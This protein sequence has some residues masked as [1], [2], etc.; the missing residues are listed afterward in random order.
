MSQQSLVLSGNLGLD[1]DSL[2]RH[3]PSTVFLVLSLA[4]FSITD[5]ILTLQILQRGGVELNPLMNLLLEFGPR[6]FIGVKYAMTASGLVVCAGFENYPAFGRTFAI[7][8]ILGALL[9]LYLSLI[10]WELRLLSFSS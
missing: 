3:R 4:L 9:L 5:A 7:R 10:A 1:P 6:W 2:D 8:A